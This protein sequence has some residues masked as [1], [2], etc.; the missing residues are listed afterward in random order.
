MEKNAFYKEI[1]RNNKLCDRKKTI[2]SK[3]LININTDFLIT[4]NMNGK[5]QYDL[6]T[7]IANVKEEDF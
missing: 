5:Q 7:D 6:N 3:N 2:L 4:S 1:V